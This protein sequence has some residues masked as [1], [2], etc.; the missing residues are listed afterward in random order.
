[1]RVMP[2]APWLIF[3]YTIQMCSLSI[4]SGLLG[5]TLTS[6]FHIKSIDMTNHGNCGWERTTLFRSS[7]HLARA[8]QEQVV[9]R[10]KHVEVGGLVGG[11]ANQI[12]AVALPEASESLRFENRYQALAQSLPTCR[13]TPSPATPP[14]LEHTNPEPSLQ[15][16][17]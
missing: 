14:P 2:D 4:S 1:M 3:S 9:Q 17:E 8:S 12:D 15:V 13:T 5:L 11:G 7:P 16:L 6:L 10:V